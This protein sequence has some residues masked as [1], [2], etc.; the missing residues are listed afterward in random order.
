MAPR[1]FSALGEGLTWKS[2]VGEHSCAHVL[3]GSLDGLQHQVYQLLVDVLVHIYL[4]GE[5][6]GPG[7][8]HDEV[9][10]LHR[11]RQQVLW[12][13]GNLETARRREG[14]ALLTTW[15]RVYTAREG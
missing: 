12:N 11:E 6:D 3:T 5:E 14:R 7:V 8:R 9:P 2:N 4:R 1:L 15:N 10:A 13:L